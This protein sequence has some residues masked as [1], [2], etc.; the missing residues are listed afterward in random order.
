MMF[1]AVLVAF[2]NRSLNGLYKVVSF[3]GNY[4]VEFLQVSR[5]VGP[6]NTTN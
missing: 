6:S 5:L 2:S 1:A 3:T 4:Q